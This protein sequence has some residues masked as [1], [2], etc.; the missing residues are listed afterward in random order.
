MIDRILERN[1]KSKF[2]KGK[3]IMLLSARQVG[4]TT[5]LKKMQRI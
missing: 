3:V 1:I 2:F 4:K 5:L